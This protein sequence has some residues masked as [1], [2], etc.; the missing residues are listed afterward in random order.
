MRSR[1]LFTPE[2]LAFLKRQGFT[3]MQFRGIEEKP[4]KN[5]RSA[6]EDDYILL[7][8]KEGIGLFEDAE[9]RVEPIE[10]T[11]VSDMLDVEFGINFWVELPAEVATAYEKLS[12]S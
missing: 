9:W 8:W 6:D 10:S 5:K 7:P 12:A 1:L 3:H 11:D 4:K 2:L